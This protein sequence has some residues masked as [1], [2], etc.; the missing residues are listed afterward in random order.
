MPGLWGLVR[1]SI[2]VGFTYPCMA[3]PTGASH[4]SWK[5][6]LVLISGW[7]WTNRSRFISNAFAFCRWPATRPSG[8]VVGITTR[9]V[10]SKR[11]STVALVPYGSVTRSRMTCMMASVPSSSPPWMLAS[12]KMGSLTF[13]PQEASRA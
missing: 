3:R 12:M 1:P 8:F 5:A 9:M 7:D 2:S 11:E 10:W 13:S 4:S 6:T